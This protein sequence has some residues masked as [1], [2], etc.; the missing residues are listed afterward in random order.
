VASCISIG[1]IAT[2][3]TWGTAHAQQPPIGDPTGRSGEP[4]PLLQQQPR[5]AP[6]QTPILPPL[7]PPRQSE[8]SPRVRVLVREVR[9][10]GSTVFTPEELTSVTAPYVNREL[11]AEDLEA[12]R[13]ALT[14]LYVNRG[15]VNSGATL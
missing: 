10:V 4:P 12:L 2:A 7:P 9:V 5:P 14:L 1:L 15:F 6:P 11:T 13:V 3:L 8:L